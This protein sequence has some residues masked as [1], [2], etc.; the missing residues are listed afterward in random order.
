MALVYKNG[1]HDKAKAQSYLVAVVRNSHNRDQ[2]LR[3]RAQ[4]LLRSISGQKDREERARLA[5][6]PSPSADE[7]DA[8]ILM[9]TAQDESEEP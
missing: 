9:T 6:D 7:Q 8:A 1:F 4:T 2:A 5:S 3:D